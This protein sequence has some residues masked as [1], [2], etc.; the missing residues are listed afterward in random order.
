ML[1]GVLDD[2]WYSSPRD[3]PSQS[4]DGIL[5]LGYTLSN[6]IISLSYEGENPLP[7]TYVSIKPYSY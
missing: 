7:S 6:P 3:D 1:A 4:W 5:E 2:G